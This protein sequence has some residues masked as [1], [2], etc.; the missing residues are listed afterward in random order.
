M[1]LEY[2]CVVGGGG[3]GVFFKNGYLAINS[4]TKKTNSKNVL[5]G[6]PVIIIK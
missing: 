3:G 4:N 6:S 2:D 1:K 5:K